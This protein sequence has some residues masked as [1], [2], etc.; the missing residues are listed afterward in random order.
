MMKIYYKMLHSKSAKAK[1]FGN[2]SSSLKSN[3]GD[4][5]SLSQGVL[6]RPNNYILT[7]ENFNH[8]LHMRSTVAGVEST[9]PASG[10]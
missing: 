1:Y 4:T 10:L 7:T 8:Q 9:V 3:P 6:A 2:L 5:F